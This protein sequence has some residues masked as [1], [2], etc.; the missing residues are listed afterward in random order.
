ML[1]QL[2]LEE[3]DRRRRALRQFPQETLYHKDIGFPADVKMPRGF[4][5]VITLRYGPHANEESMRDKY[6]NIRLP[7]RVD[8]R[9][10]EI[11]EIGVRNN[12][13]SKLGVRFSYDDTRDLILIINPAD[14]FVRTVW[15]NLKGDKHRTLD[16]SKYTKPRKIA[17]TT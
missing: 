5:P 14:G 9:R 13:V 17:A 12:V 3:L 11:F 2:I 4:H 10:G 7:K 16:R 8:V 1:I 15:F 6:G